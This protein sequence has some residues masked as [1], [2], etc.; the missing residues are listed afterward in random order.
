[1]NIVFA[2]NGE[3]GVACLRTLLA[4]GFPVAGV[5]VHPTPTQSNPSGLAAFAEES[6]LPIRAP[7]DVNDS[8]ELAQIAQWRPDVI[9]LAGYGQ[10]VKR[11]FIKLAPNGCINLHAGKLPE[12]RGSSPL[13][14]A[15]INGETEFGLSIIRVDE[16]VD[17]GEVLKDRVYPVRPTDTIADLHRTANHA[18]PDMLLEVLAELEHGT[19]RPRQQEEGGAKYFP[20][21]FPEDGHILWDLYSAEQIH[22]RIRALTDPYPGA[23]TLYRG[24]RVKLLASKLSSREFG[25]EP[26]RVYM[27]NHNGLLVC[28]LDKCLWISSARLEPSGAD[29]MSLVQRYHKFVT[30]RDMSW[31]FALRSYQA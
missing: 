5:I 2:G 21:R 22:N 31:E 23:L 20:L 3:R 11:D 8:R 30:V 4:K 27:K 28:A 9:V 1:M 12:Y 24:Q 17:T 15:L 18:F 10:I 19:L 14:W 25:G 29:A 16:G 13:N 26:G 7:I 6:R